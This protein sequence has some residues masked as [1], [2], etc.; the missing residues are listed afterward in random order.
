MLR[1]LMNGKVILVTGGTGSF[2]RRFIRMTLEKS[3]P[4]KIIVYSRDEM[5]QWEME[6]EF[7]S[8]DKKHVLRFFIG[9]VRDKERMHRAFAG[10]D[11][12]IHAAAMKILPIAEYNPLECIKT[13]IMG[14]MN[15]IECAVEQKV[16]KVV[17]LSTDKASN[18]V[19]LYGATKLCS[20]KLFVA[21]NAY[22]GTQKT[23]FFVFR[24]GNGM[25]SLGYI[26]SCFLSIS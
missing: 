18:P 5:K 15:V 13:N 6:K 10:V 21:G 3:S 8:I 4:K 12:V 11:Y 1:G 24:Y 25:G 22:S 19:N 2:G 26:I 16:E 20:D 9:D 7:S 23:R 17:A 14:A